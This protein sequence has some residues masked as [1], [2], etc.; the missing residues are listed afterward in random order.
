MRHDFEKYLES[1]KIFFDREELFLLC[2]TIEKILEDGKN[3]DIAATNQMV[4]KSLDR[5]FDFVQK[6][7]KVENS[8]EK[9]HQIFKCL[10]PHC[11]KLL[12]LPKMNIKLKDDI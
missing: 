9:F 11:Y 2:K 1:E 7:A 3:Q 12:D 5:I 4:K 10:L 6:F 8:L